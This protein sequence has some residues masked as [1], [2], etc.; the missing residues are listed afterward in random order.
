MYS[1]PYRQL[2]DRAIG[3][4]RREKMGAI[5]KM[6]AKAKSDYVFLDLSQG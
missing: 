6:A 5:P 3:L 4:T 1:K 2:S